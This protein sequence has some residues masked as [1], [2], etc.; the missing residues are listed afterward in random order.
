MNKENS[1]TFYPDPGKKQGT[2]IVKLDHCQRG[3][4]QGRVIWAEENK[5]RRFRSALEL[6]KLI[7]GAVSTGQ[8]IQS[9]AE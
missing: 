4:W 7:D 6:I 2:F 8:E 9:L 1:K 5:I 3:T